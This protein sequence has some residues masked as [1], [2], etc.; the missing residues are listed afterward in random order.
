[1]RTCRCVSGSIPWLRFSAFRFGL[2]QVDRLHQLR[3]GLGWNLYTKNL[4]N[5]NAHDHEF[6][7]LHPR[8]QSTHQLVHSTECP[9]KTKLWQNL[10]LNRESQLLPRLRKIR[11][12]GVIRFVQ[13]HELSLKQFLLKSRSQLSLDSKR[14]VSGKGGFTFWWVSQGHRSCTGCLGLDICSAFHLDFSRHGQHGRYLCNLCWLF[15]RCVLIY[16]RVW[17]EI[18]ADDH[19]SPRLTEFE[20][21]FVR[22]VNAVFLFHQLA[23]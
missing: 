23:L 15:I 8:T 11:G 12:A 9:F 6:P 10:F 5:L 4:V 19:D 7:V 2:W 22:F 17:S 14:L 20:V 1:M 21:V 16:R 18:C 3:P 13:Y